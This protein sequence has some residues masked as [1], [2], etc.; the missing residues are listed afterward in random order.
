MKRRP[1]AEPALRSPHAHRSNL[2][3]LYKKGKVPQAQSTAPDMSAQSHDLPGP[4]RLPGENESS[5]RWLPP[6][7]NREQKQADN[8]VVPALKVFHHRIPFPCESTTP[9]QALKH[10][11][12]LLRRL[13]QHLT[14]SLA[15]LPQKRGMRISLSLPLL[16]IIQVH[17]SFYLIIPI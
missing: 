11:E 7:K 5:V 8:T 14:F 2:L 17:L 12:R 4:N 15:L 16:I 9:V 6:S 10:C 13:S 1:A 3:F